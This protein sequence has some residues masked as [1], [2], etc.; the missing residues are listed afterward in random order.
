MFICCLIPCLSIFKGFKVSTDISKIYKT[1][2]I[3]NLTETV[4]TQTFETALKNNGINFKKIEV[5]TNKIDSDSIT[6]SEVKV[7]SKDNVQ[8]IKE[9]FGNDESFKVSIINE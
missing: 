5:C 9:L 6:I 1:D 4:I 2:N 7:Y 8:K 3:T